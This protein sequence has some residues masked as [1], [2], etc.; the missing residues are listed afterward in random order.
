LV[1]RLLIEVLGDFDVLCGGWDGTREN[2]DSE[3]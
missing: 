3:A 1:F 2:F